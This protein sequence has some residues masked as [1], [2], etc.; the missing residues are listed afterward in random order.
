MN[1][2]ASQS[3]IVIY[4]NAEKPV[5]VWLDAGRETVWLSQRQ[6]AEVFDSST[7]NIGLHLKNIYNVGELEE[8]ATTEESSVVRQEGR[9]KVTRQQIKHF[10]LDAIIS[11]GYR[12]NS[13]PANKEVMIRLIM[14]MLAR[15]NTT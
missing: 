10:N 4:Q 6:M 15:E 1:E 11:A 12:V 2:A 5:E 13:R 9:R 8:P 7:D 14:N 3:A